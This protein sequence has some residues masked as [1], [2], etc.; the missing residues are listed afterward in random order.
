MSTF[1]IE[2]GTGSGFRARVSDEKRLLVS[3][4]IQDVAVVRSLGGNAFGIN[5]GDITLTTAS[6]SAVF[7]LK[8]N[9]DKPLI[10]YTIGFAFGSSTGGSGNGR[11]QLVRN[12]TAGTIVSGAQSVE[13]FEN[14]NF[15]SANTCEVD[16]FK[17]AEGNTFTN[18][19]NSGKT[20]STFPVRTTTTTPA[21][22]LPRGSSF[23]AVITPPPGNTSCL[24]QVFVSFFMGNSI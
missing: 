10:F 14:L 7:F 19:S 18:G 20:F 22:I 3:A 16:A 4:Q 8:N 6:P 17:G 21:I 24:L 5:T 13:I 1:V 23:G 9:E 11:I 2:D 15:G 12:P